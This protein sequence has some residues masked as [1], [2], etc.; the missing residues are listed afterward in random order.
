[1]VGLEMD[2]GGIP[3]RMILHPDGGTDQVATREE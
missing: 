2:E 3:V 1:M